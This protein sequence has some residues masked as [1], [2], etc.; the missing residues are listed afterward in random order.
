MIVLNQ[1]IFALHPSFNKSFLNENILISIEEKLKGNFEDV[2][3]KIKEHTEDVKAILESEIY[4]LDCILNNCYTKQGLKIGKE[5]SAIG[6]F[7]NFLKGS[8]KFWVC[9][10]KFT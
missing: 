5:N 6:I 1:A 9:Q 8:K 4:E 2:N 10:E 7:K 3:E